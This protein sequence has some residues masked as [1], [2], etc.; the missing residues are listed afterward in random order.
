MSGE[1]ELPPGWSILEKTG[2]TW[3]V[4]D[5][6]GTRRASM[7]SLDDAI[8]SA[9]HAFGVTREEFQAMR[10]DHQAMEIVRKLNP[11]LAEQIIAALGESSFQSGNGC[12]DEK[13]GA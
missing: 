4:I 13:G 7:L 8:E 9:W 2:P 1:S 5:H 12:G 11:D 6:L 3:W 10:R